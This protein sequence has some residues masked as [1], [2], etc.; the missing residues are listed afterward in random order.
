MTEHSQQQSIEQPAQTGRYARQVIFPEL[1]RDGQ[2]RLAEATVVVVGCGATGTA[3]S[4]LLARMGVGRLRIIDRDFIELNNLQRQMLFDEEDI[5]AALPKAE[6]AARK[7]RRANSEIVVESVV[8]DVNPGNVLALLGDATVVM[9]GTDNFSTRY[10]LNDACLQLG[11][12]WVYSGVIAS[13][14]MTV[15]LI[16]AEA[17][18]ALP[19]GRQATGCLRCLLGEMPAPGTTPTCDTAGVIGPAV[20]LITAVAAG[21]A[22]KLIVGRGA[23]NP[24]ILHMDVWTH[25]YEQFGAGGRRPDC[26]ACGRRE[27]E[28]LRAQVGATSASLCGR[29]AV[30][31]SV[32]GSKPLDL[33]RLEEQLLP[34]AGQVRRNE[35]LLKARINSYELTVFP[36]NRAIIQGTDDEDVAKGLYAK[37]IGA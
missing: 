4:N 16:P 34:V 32:L 22:M 7:L 26:P 18:A 1:G 11:K 19:G 27:F 21:E 30:Q 35:H 15:T 3:L 24:G 33:A 36:D 29:N 9:D 12:P 13:Y 6:A 23:L 31:V 28:F 14:G 10:L 17:A 2:E 25:E 8:A 20:A 37:Y 5:A